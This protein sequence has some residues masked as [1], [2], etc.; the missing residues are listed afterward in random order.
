MM[1][2]FPAVFFPYEI[3]FVISM[4]AQNEHPASCTYLK[5]LSGTG[6]IFYRKTKPSILIVQGP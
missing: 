3:V 2:L 5:I 1:W 4:A 6:F